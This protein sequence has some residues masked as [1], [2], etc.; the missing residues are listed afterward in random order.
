MV[1]INNT[2][3]SLSWKRSKLL[4]YAEKE[5]SEWETIQ[6]VYYVVL[7]SLNAFRNFYVNL[8]NYYYNEKEKTALH[9]QINTDVFKMDMARID[10]DPQRN[11]FREYV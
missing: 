4:E 3:W 8:I 9:Y 11:S 10:D 5:K 7:V 2:E 1:C 6:V